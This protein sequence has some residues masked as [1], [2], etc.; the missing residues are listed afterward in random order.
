MS[1]RLWLASCCFFIALPSLA[2]TPLPELF[3]KAKQQFNQASYSE[4]LKTLDEM[5]LR[6]S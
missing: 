3:Q 5:A 2:S 1:K 4:A 6:S